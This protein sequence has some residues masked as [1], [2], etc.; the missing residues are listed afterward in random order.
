MKSLINMF[1][2]FVCAWGGIGLIYSYGNQNS[3][4]IEATNSRELET[5]PGV[6]NRKISF[7]EHQR[8]CKELK[9]QHRSK[10]EKTYIQKIIVESKQAISPNSYGSCEC[11]LYNTLSKYIVLQM[12]LEV[13]KLKRTTEMD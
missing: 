13:L 3:G 5:V 11:R 6:V 1:L 10:K 8:I 12:K 2:G 4:Y 9:K 7:E